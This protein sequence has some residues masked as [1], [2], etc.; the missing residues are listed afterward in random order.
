MLR[1]CHDTALEEGKQW[2]K[3][4]SW[5]EFRLL[6]GVCRHFVIVIVIIVTLL[7][8]LSRKVFTW[9]QIARLFLEMLEWSHCICI[10]FLPKKSQNRLLKRLF[11]P[12]EWTWHCCWKLVDFRCVYFCNLNSLPSPKCLYLWL[13]HTVLFSHSPPPALE[14]DIFLLFLFPP[15]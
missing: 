7:M 2:K 4:T 9:I 11:F 1:F 3:P 6:L 5:M 12:V 8:L 13:D 14:G 15:I 10:Y